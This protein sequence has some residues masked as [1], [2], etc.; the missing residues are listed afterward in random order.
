[1]EDHVKMLE[2]E[3]KEKQRAQQ[4]LEGYGRAAGVFDFVRSS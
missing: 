3:K 1:M 2:K 4:L